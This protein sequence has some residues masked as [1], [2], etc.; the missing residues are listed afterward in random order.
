[1]RTVLALFLTVILLA[2][3]AAPPAWAA[4]DKEKESGRHPVAVIKAEVDRD[5]FDSGTTG[6]QR[7]CTLWIKNLSREDMQKIKVKL[8]VFGNRRE[9]EE[10]EKEIEELEAGARVF[11]TFKWEDF[12]NA[13]KQN[14]QIWLT[15]TND[16]GEEVTFQAQSP[17]W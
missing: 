8:K 3:M 10:M 14:I 17:V 12:S 15:Y 1:M 2:G 5:G 4:K 16:E 6:V 11:V 7:R 9:L 13:K